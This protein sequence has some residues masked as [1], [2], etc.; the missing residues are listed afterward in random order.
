MSVLPS[1]CNGPS[2]PYFAL[3]YQYTNGSIKI[4][5]KLNETCQLQVKTDAEYP[6]SILVRV[7]LLN[8]PPGFVYSNE[9]GECICMVNHNHQNPAISDCEL[10]SYQA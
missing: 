9:K 5:G 4:A 3:P 2:S 8:C 7:V 6:V 10:T 1:T